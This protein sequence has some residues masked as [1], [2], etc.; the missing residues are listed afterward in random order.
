M[1]VGIILNSIGIAFPKFHKSKKPNVIVKDYIHC[2]V[3]VRYRFS[4][5]DVANLRVFKFIYCKFLIS[6]FWESGIPDPDFPDFWTM[7][8]NENIRTVSNDFNGF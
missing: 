7:E 6:N 8:L 4:H 5:F 3:C 2:I 1:Y